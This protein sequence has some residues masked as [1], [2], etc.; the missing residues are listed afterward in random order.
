M[1]QD[2]TAIQIGLLLSAEGNKMQQLVTVVA[3]CC[4]ESSLLF[5][6]SAGL[7]SLVTIEEF[8]IFLNYI[9]FI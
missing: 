6:M 3:S 4:F 2:P 5:I 1:Q 9:L 8:F 7:I